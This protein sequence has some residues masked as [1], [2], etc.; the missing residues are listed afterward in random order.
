VFKDVLCAGKESTFEFIEGV[1]DE[2][3]KLFPSKYIHVGGDECPKDRWQA[4]ERC[5]ARI[6]EEGLKDEKELQSWFLHRAEKML[7]ARGRVMVGWDEIHEGGVPGDA[8]V[9]WWVNPRASRDAAKL[10]HTVISS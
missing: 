10:G 3:V 4:H 1:L 7:K 8:I 5:Q 9:H 2:V 6:R